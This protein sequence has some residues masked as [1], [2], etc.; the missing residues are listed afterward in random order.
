MRRLSNSNDVSNIINLFD[1]GA[2][3]SPAG[4]ALRSFWSDC[5]DRPEESQAD[6][7]SNFV[8]NDIN[9]PGEIPTHIFVRRQYTHHVLITRPYKLVSACLI[10]DLMKKT[11]LLY[12]RG[13]L[14]RWDFRGYRSGSCGFWS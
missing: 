10:S 5:V 6:I 13:A 9:R 7:D 8:L 11:N 12:D 1:E 2:L 3:A 4:P 14:G